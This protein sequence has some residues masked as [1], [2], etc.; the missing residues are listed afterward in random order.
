MSDKFEIKGDVNLTEL[1]KSLQD[2]L[3]GE[4]GVELEPELAESTNRF[5]LE[6]GALYAAVKGLAALTPLI[7]GVL[8]F[9]KS[10]KESGGGKEARRLRIVAKDDSVLEVPED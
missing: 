4:S 1:T 2:S 10:R 3:A 8:N 5:V 6:V 9:V 7:L